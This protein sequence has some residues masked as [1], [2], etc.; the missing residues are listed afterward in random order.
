M[1]DLVENEIAVLEAVIADRFWER[2]SNVGHKQGKH[3]L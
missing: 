3:L 1:V 2:I